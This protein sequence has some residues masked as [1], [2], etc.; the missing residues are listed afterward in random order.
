MMWLLIFV[1]FMYVQDK[2]RLLRACTQT[3]YTTHRLSTAF[4]FWWVVPTAVI[5]TVVAWWGKKA[6]IPQ[7]WGLPTFVG[8]HWLYLVP[9][10][11]AVVYSSV[12]M[13]VFYLMDFATPRD[14]T[15]TYETAMAREKEINQEDYFNTNMVHCLRKKSTQ[16]AVIPCVLGKMYLQPNAVKR[17]SKD[18]EYGHLHS[19]DNL[20][21]GSAQSSKS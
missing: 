2:Y 21:T 9:L 19:A 8:A 18:V 6:G 10:A 5:A 20:G 3:S 16:D 13:L 12:L 4:A 15:E 11:H 14:M 1:I 7:E 17:F